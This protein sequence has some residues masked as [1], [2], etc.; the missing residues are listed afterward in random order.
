MKKTIEKKRRR[1]QRSLGDRKEHYRLYKAGKTWLIAGIAT[2]TFG[3]T[4]TL[5]STQHAF[6][7]DEISESATPTTGAATAGAANTDDETDANSV[8]LTDSTAD[9]ASTTADS[10]S[11]AASDTT[12]SANDA[13]ANS[14]SDTSDTSSDTTAS[15]TD[16]ATDTSDADSTTTTTADSTST[17]DAD[18]TAATSTD[19]TSTSNNDS[20]SE[21]ANK[22]TTATDDSTSA[23]TTTDD[24]SSNG[25]STVTDTT[26]SNNGS[27]TTSASDTTGSTATGDATL[28][29]PATDVSGTTATTPDDA[30]VTPD[31][32]TDE[33]ASV[34]D[35]VSGDTT[36]AA[37]DESISVTGLEATT[38]P[39]VITRVLA[40]SATPAATSIDAVSTS[41]NGGAANESGTVIYNTTTATATGTTVVN[42]SGAF[43][44]GDVLTVT[45]G[46]NGFTI[47][48]VASVS[49]A[50]TTTGSTTVNNVSEP[51]VTVT[52]NSD[53]S[54][55]SF[56]IYYSFNNTANN[57]LATGDAEDAVPVTV[58]LNG[59]TV[60]TNTVVVDKTYSANNGTANLGYNLFNAG[61]STTI[62]G[63][64]IQNGTVVQDITW[65][66]DLS[67]NRYPGDYS[68]IPTNSNITTLS[69][70]STLTFN[71]P[72][73]VEVTAASL[74][75]SL[76]AKGMTVTQTGNT[77]TVTYP[78]GMTIASLSSLAGNLKVSISAVTTPTTTTTYTGTNLA[79]TWNVDGSTVTV[80]DSNPSSRA[81]L[82]QYTNQTVSAIDTLSF[83]SNSNSDL[84][85]FDDSANGST[86]L[87]WTVL[88]SSNYAYG[89]T[90]NATR[91]A[92][93]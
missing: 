72:S 33:T 49:G 50:T 1:L 93:H 4:A 14:T 35:N 48:S 34:A 29:T 17:S 89:G 26:S 80:T 22:T 45:M 15:D 10:N 19:S 60:A 20:S 63:G 59:S 28:T 6:A 83:N 41:I 69:S 56:N 42:V 9:A 32:S 92:A 90:L 77:I 62:T 86:Q 71:L 24:T 43:N 3:V 31:L 38:T 67:G 75:S 54:A 27:D 5:N 44:S 8:V 46:S 66:V 64:L 88:D 16:T 74:D 79:M 82:L 61:S 21:T 40:A 30:T 13:T 53:V 12:S 68:T 51:Q 11:G 7:D 84:S 52:F 70:P 55:A 25:D 91:M 65:T 73:T 76:T 87:N 36:V 58:A 57:T 81:T 23:A 39:V 37:A 78:E 47:N 2:V 85:T 18:T